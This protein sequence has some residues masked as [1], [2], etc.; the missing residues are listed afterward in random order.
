MYPTLYHFFKGAM[1]IEIE[2]LRI[3]PMLGFWIGIAFL[4]ANFFGAR[5]L[6][7]R[8]GLGLIK[9]QKKT[10]IIGKPASALDLIIN[11]VYGFIIGFKFIPLFLDSS[12]FGDFVGFLL[13][14]KG[15]LVAGILVGIGMAVWKY[16][17]AN[18][19]K[20]ET[21]IEK[22]YANLSENNE[23]RDELFWHVACL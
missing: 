20:L 4:A 16:W 9:T 13:S 12:I 21:P 19:E 2:F 1:G 18:K 3:I 5:E 8:E 22:E 14:S 23:L 11:G 7:R 10:I 17:E 15:N 6:K